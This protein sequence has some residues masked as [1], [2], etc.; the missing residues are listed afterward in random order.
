MKY[1]VHA[2]ARRDLRDAARYYK[3]RAGVGFAQ[4]F[5][6]AFEQA[7]NVLLTQ[8]LAGAPWHEEKRRF[9]LKRFPYSVIYSIQD[10]QVRVFAVAH[11]SRRPDFWQT[12]TWRD[13]IR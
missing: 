1:A 3:E 11:H 4:S 9:V 6:S 8:P 7:M 13:S 5:L 12:R 10:N 2:E